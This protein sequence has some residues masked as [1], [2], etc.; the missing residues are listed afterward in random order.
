MG[1]N[2]KVSSAFF[3]P[4]KLWWD[5]TGEF[6]LVI[7]QVQRGVAPIPKSLKK[8]RIEENINI[9]DFELSYEEMEELGEFVFV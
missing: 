3:P 1:R 9:F 5:E 7:I 6:N 2:R 4:H 8:H